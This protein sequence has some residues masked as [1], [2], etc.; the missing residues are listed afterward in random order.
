MFGAIEGGGTKFVCAVGTG[1]DDMVI[2]QFPTTSPEATI[3]SALTFLKE[4]SGGRLQ[5]VGIGS[6]G[7]VDLRPSS[8][9][10]GYVTSTPKPGWQNFDF[11]GAVRK[12]LDVPVGFDTDVDAAALGEARWGAAQSISDFLYLTVGTGIGAGVIVN[13]QILHGLVHP[14]VGHIR[15]PH[16]RQR[17]PYPGCCPF[18][19]DC[20]EGLACGPSM[21]KRWGK[22]ARELPIDHPA[23]ALEA[24]YLALGLTNWVCTLS[25]KRMILGGGVMQQQSLFPLVRA[26][27][28]HLLNGY[29]R[30]TELIENIERY[31]VPPKLGNRAGIA[32]AL[33]LAEQAYHEQQEGA[34][35]AIRSDT[36]A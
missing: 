29:V 8:T 9:T 30:S 6:F 20:L 23:W 17:D 31:V 32:G 25:P 16:D 3:H 21:E 7:P 28:I 15:I 36:R 35:I 19:G 33:V 11:A 24:H 10:F 2:T 26:E 34:S 13:G 12:G 1:P 14:E 22:P 18:H 4:R 5:A 27:L